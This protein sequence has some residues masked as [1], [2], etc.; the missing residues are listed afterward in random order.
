MD[1]RLTTN[2]HAILGLLSITPMSGYDLHLA[3]ERAVGRFWPVSKSQVYAE[4]SRLQSAGLIEGSEVR[5]QAL[6]DKRVFRLTETGERALDAW[7]A[8]DEQADPQFR[9]PFLL[10]VLFGHR[11]TADDTAGLLRGVYNRASDQATQYEDYL[12]LLAKTPDSAYAQI[13]VLFGLRLAEAIAAWA[14]EA[15]ALLP[16]L[17]PRLDPRREPRTAAAMLRSV[18]PVR[19]TRS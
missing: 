13:T 19:P 6:P 11:R 12:K 14:Q 9:I 5:Q 4:L 1:A 15:Q 7:L 17:A 18:P 10:K 3:V 8:S 2:S 16:E